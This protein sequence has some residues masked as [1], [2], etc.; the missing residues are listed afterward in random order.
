MTTAGVAGE[1]F[2]VGV[3]TMSRVGDIEAALAEVIEFIRVGALLLHAELH[4]APRSGATL[5]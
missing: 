3:E 4:A 5:H 1:G 2:G